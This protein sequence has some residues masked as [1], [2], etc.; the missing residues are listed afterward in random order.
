MQAL[1]TDPQRAIQDDMVGREVS[2]LFERDGRL[3]GQK[4]GKSEYLHAVH[5]IAPDIAMGDLRRVRIT[6]SH[7]NSLAGVLI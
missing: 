2:V 5:V 6:E 4:S 1:L 3:E 7:A